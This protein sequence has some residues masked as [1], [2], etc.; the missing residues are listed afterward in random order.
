MS[1]AMGSPAAHSARVQGPAGVTAGSTRAAAGSAAPS[2]AGI[3]SGEPMTGG[4]VLGTSQGVESPAA[5]RRRARWEWST[6]PWPFPT[7]SA[8]PW[9]MASCS[10][11]VDQASASCGDS[12]PPNRVASAEAREHPVPWVLV[13]LTRI[14]GTGRQVPS[15]STQVFVTVAESRCP[16]FTTTAT[17]VRA[18]HPRAWS[19]AACSSRARSLPVRRASSS[20][21]G[22][23]TVAREQKVIMACSAS[24]S[25]RLSPLVATITGSTTRICGGCSSSHSETVAMSAAVPSMPVLTASITTSSLTARS[26]W[27]RN[28]AGGTWMSRTPRVFWATSAVTTLMP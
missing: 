10:H 19:R 3:W 23:T 25:S 7:R 18:A 26:C 12:P 6:G 11:W 16:V 21:F 13:E 5:C 9:E 14:E 4:T 27:S 24:G 8:S 1:R 20:M 2:A 15:G 22:V 28:G 17:P